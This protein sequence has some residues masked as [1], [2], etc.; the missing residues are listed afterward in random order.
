MAGLPAVA[1]ASPIAVGR[2]SGVFGVRGWLKL[3]SFT[4]PPGNLLEYRPWQVLRGGEFVPL[5]VAEI[6]HRGQILL[7]RLVGVDTRD[8]AAEWVGREVFITR[9][10][11]PPPAPG[12]VYW[13][14]MIGLPVVNRAGI[15]L[16]R[17]VR[18]LETGAHDVLV[19][20]GEVERLIPFVRG[21][22]VLE[23]DPQQGRLLVDWEA[24][25]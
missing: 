1:P 14:D 23:A 19:V 8:T 9:D 13:A 10:Q 12:E 21:V 7:V 18:L 17:V 20:R 24:D 22:H 16:G 3:F 5:E 11:L 15:D 2:F 6:D 4:R 25:Y